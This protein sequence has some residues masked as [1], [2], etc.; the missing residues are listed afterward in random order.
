[1][2][3]TWVMCRVWS[4]T[5]TS[6]LWEFR[7][8]FGDIN[9]AKTAR[10]SRKKVWEIRIPNSYESIEAVDVNSLWLNEETD[11][12]FLGCGDSRILG[13]NLEGGQIMKTYSEHKDYIHCLSGLENRLYSASEDGSVK[14][15][16]L[17]QKKSTGSVEP[18]KNHELFRPQMGKWLGTVS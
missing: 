13:I 2:S 9:G 10:R 6:L 18:Y 8:R 14:F 16:D 4:S 7:E 11:E 5:R 1:M 3:Q 15:W 17:R 12:V